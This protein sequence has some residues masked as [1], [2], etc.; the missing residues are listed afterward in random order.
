MAEAATGRLTDGAAALPEDVLF[1]IFSRVENVSDLLRCAMTCKPWRQLFTDRAFLRRL[2]P[3][4]QGQ[5]LRSHLLGFFFQQK[6]FVRR[7]KMMKARARQ[8]SLRL[9]ARLP[10]GTGVTARP[11]GARPHRLRRLPA[12]VL[13][14]T[15]WSSIETG[16]KF[17]HAS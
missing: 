13:R 9:R 17:T 15:T 3:D 4:Q 5:G 10:A 14:V 7:M 2:W 8:H 1:E 12:G 16:N 11:Q 6:G